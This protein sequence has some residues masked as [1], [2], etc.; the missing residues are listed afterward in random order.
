[1]GAI[2]PQDVTRQFD[3]RGLIGGINVGH[4]LTLL[5]VLNIKA[6]DV[7]VSKMFS[8]NKSKGALCCRHPW[9]LE[10]K[11]NLPQNLKPP[12]PYLMMLYMKFDHF[13]PTDIRDKLLR[14]YDQT[15]STDKETD[16]WGTPD[17]SYTNISLALLAKLS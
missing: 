16:G 2:N 13:C 11:S 6:V 8:H 3:P 12:F 5:H 4:H 15:T 1:M 7:M 17:N 10:F 9:Q 14:K